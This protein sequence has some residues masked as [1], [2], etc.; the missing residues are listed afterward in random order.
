MMTM[1]GDDKFVQTVP[2][3]VTTITITTMTMMTMM[4]MIVSKRQPTNINS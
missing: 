4:T 2:V 1:I 3:V